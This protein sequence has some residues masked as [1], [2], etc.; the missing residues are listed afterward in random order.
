[1]KGFLAENSSG[2]EREHGEDFFTL[3]RIVFKD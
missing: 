3:K 2:I 1:M